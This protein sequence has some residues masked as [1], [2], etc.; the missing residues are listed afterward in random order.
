VYERIT[1]ALVA[2]AYEFKIAI[3]EAWDENYG[4][5]GASGGANLPFVLTT[6]FEPVRFRFVGATNVPSVR[7][8]EA[9]GAAAGLVASAALAA[10]RRSRRR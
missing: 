4:E 8:P 7:V 9:G 3:G 1:T 2:G 6:D 5:G 10:L